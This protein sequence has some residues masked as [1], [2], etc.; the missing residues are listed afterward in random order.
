MD[1]LIAGQLV[2]S[3]SGAATTGAGHGRTTGASYACDLDGCK[4]V[5]VG[6]VWSDGTIKYPCSREM[7]YDPA[8]DLWIMKSVIPYCEYDTETH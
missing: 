5:R 7:T 6:V 8:D 2:R 1:S 4:Y 3:E